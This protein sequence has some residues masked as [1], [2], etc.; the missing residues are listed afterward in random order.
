MLPLYGTQ[1]SSTVLLFSCQTDEPQIDIELSIGATIKLTCTTRQS[2]DSAKNPRTR[3]HKIEWFDPQDKR[4]LQCPAERRPATVM[5]CSLEPG[6]QRTFQFGEY[7]CIATNGYDHCSSGKFSPNFYTCK[8]NDPEGSVA[9]VILL[10]TSV[11]PL[12]HE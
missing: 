1:A 12:S 5:N 4:I 6:A 11:C 7:T 9:K 10:S 8:E 3:P 2:N